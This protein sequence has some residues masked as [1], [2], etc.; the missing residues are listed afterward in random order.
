MSRPPK[1]L[2]TR[3]SPARYVIPILA[4]KV[5]RLLARLRG[6]GS[7]FPG[8][9]TLKLAPRFL[10]DITRQFTHGNVFV[11]GSNGKST[12][13]HML[14][15][16]MRA[17]GLTVFTNPSG[18]NLPQGIASSLLGQV[19]LSGRL[20]ADIGVIEVDEA[21]G[22][23][24]AEALT[25]SAAVIL[26]LQIDQ[27]YRF[28]EPERV[29]GMFRDIVAEVSDV[30][31]LN[32][33]DHFLRTLAGRLE[34]EGRLDL[35]FFGLTDEAVA[36][37]PHGQVIARDYENESISSHSAREV[38]AEVQA[39]D[40]ATATIAFDGVARSVTLSA[41]GLH[42]AVDAAAA[43]TLARKVLSERFSLDTAISAL[44]SAKPV[45]GRGETVQHDGQDLEILLLKNLASFQMNVDYLDGAPESVMIALDEGSKDLSWL[46]AADVSKF[47][48]VDVVSGPKAAFMA[49]RL[50]YDNIDY[51]TVEPD[52]EKAL[53]TM[54]ASELP[55]SGK[56]T[57]ILDYDQMILARKL[58]GHSDLE[59][60][61]S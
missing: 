9:V 60:G 4:G 17:H 48:H 38:Y 13:T 14:T 29:A 58:L 37:A 30:V 25:P 41:R 6:G 7:A 20:N 18:G 33:D 5:V 49:L 56:R 22:K 19:S 26:N 35:G 27:I 28:H 16:I 11:L 59:R 51:G 50:A 47:S 39:V 55:S 34:E 53:N 61:A 15:S 12:T 2:G 31:V 36:S 43:I 45:Y 54:L 32:R 1:P 24:I 21:F 44:E 46:Y 57:L 42:Y 3:P 10:H 52:L 40:G 23:V 8:Y